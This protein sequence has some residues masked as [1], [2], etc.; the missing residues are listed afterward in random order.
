MERKEEE[1]MQE[2]ELLIIKKKY[3]LFASFQHVLCNNVARVT[4]AL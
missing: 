2:M 3:F 4:Y 1:K